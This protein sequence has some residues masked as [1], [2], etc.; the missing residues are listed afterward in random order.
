M[1][2]DADRFAMRAWTACGAV[3]GG[4]VGFLAAP[5]LQWRLR[6]LGIDQV[7]F[8]PALVIIVLAAVFGSVVTWR[9][10]RR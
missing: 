6:F 4:L 2:D 8:G 10:A 7:A 3:G 9:A 1:S 5:R